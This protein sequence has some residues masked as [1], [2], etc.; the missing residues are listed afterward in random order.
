MGEKDEVLAVLKGESQV[1]SRDGQRGNSA[2]GE[3]P[4]QA[5]R[6]TG[7]ALAYLPCKTN[8]QAIHSQDRGQT[9]AAATGI[10]F[11]MV[12]DIG[13]VIAEE[14]PG[15]PEEMNKRGMPDQRSCLLLTLSTVGTARQML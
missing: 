13:I 2:G 15:V 12:L 10:A 14:L 4:P 8:Q 11:Q 7:N 5:I 6:G 3:R 1:G 9:Q